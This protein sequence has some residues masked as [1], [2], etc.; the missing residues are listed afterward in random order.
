MVLTLSANRLLDISTNKIGVNHK[1]RFIFPPPCA[2]S[3]HSS[4]RHHKQKQLYISGA[5][6]LL[7]FSASRLMWRVSVTRECQLVNTENFVLSNECE[8]AGWRCRAINFCEL[9]NC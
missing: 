5:S 7:L 2:T 8:V 3:V 6:W 4:C 9:W 1:N